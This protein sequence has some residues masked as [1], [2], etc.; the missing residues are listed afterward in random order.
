MLH[1]STHMQC[2]PRPLAKG[3][4]SSDY[5]TN[6]SGRKPHA[7]AKARHLWHGS[8][9]TLAR[10]SRRKERIAGHSSAEETATSTSKTERGK[11]SQNP[12]THRKCSALK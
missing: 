6:A 9:P 1:I 11:V 2:P 12:L 4:R 3:V 5:S 7:D 8:D 10:R